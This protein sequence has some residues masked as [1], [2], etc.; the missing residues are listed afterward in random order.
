MRLGVSRL[1]GKF[2]HA[3]E[4]QNLRMD[5]HSA[6]FDALEAAE[7]QRDGI[8]SWIIEFRALNPEMTMPENP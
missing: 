7:A 5:A 6:R 3:T 8:R 1:E 2:D 4:M